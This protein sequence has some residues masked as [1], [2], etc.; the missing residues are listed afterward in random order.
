MSINERYKA[1]KEKHLKKN[2]EIVIQ[3]NVTL[4]SAQFTKLS[5]YLIVAVKNVKPVKYLLRIFKHIITP[6]LVKRD[7][8]QSL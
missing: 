3:K 4:I 7:G 5:I 1:E 8:K 2:V 6:L